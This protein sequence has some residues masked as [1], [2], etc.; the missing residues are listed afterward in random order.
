MPVYCERGIAELPRLYLN[1]GKR[2]YIISLATAELLRVLQPT[3]V[4]TAV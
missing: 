3:L 2:G 1:G 4:S